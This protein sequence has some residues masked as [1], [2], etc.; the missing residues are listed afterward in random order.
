MA[1]ITKLELGVCEV[2]IDGV[3]LGHTKGGVEVTY[4]P[5]YT[6]ISV[7][8]YGETVVDKRLIGEKWMAKVPLAEYTI[9]N[10]RKAMPQTQ[11]AGAGNARITI[12]AKA[13][14]KASD[15]AVEL[16]LHPQDK[17]T[18]EHDIVM[19]KAYASSQVVINH[20]NDDIKIIEVTFEALLDESHSDGNYLGMIGDSTA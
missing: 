7:D 8:A 15:D 6:D 20:V 1:D 17:G 3:N 16:L 11:F 10:L 12:G 18:R 19:Y 14:K 4:E 5:I 2:S 9:A 13:G